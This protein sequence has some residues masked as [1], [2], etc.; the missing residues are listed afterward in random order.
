MQDQ[1]GACAGAESYEAPVLTLGMKP[2]RD[3]PIRTESASL[4][5]D[6]LKFMRL[7]VS[8]QVY[9]TSA[10]ASAKRIL[11]IFEFGVSCCVCWYSWVGSNHRP[12]VPQTGALTN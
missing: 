5:L 7:G 12:P 6:A 4:A 3:G 8:A 9:F 10:I 2:K 11:E 1:A